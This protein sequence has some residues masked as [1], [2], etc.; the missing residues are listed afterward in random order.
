MLFRSCHP[1]QHPRS[2]DCIDRSDWR[3]RTLFGGYNI[4]YKGKKSQKTSRGNVAYTILARTR[5]IFAL[6]K[7]SC[8]E[9]RSV[10]NEVTR[11]CMRQLCMYI[12]N[13]TKKGLVINAMNIFHT[14]RRSL[15]LI[16]SHFRRLGTSDESDLTVYI[17][18]ISSISFPLLYCQ[19]KESEMKCCLVLVILNS[20]HD[21]MIAMTDRIEEI[22]PCLVAT[23]RVI[24][25][26]KVKNDL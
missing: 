19:K 15:L 2:N 5:K 24:K 3:N 7:I 13:N 16:S 18:N 23:T 20:I 12:L 6:T 17:Y 10:K 9:N 21:R 26:K 1:K 25:L 8:K 4:R 14:Q 11:C 22:E